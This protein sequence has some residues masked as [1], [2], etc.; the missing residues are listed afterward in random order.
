MSTFPFICFGEVLWDQ[1]PDGPRIGGAP[2][3][4]AA[5][6]HNLGV[7]SYLVSA[8]GKDV[9]GKKILEEMTGRGLSTRYVQQVD[10]VPTG[11]VHV[12]EISGKPSYEISKEAAWDQ[13]GFRP[14]LDQLAASARAICFGSLSQRNETSRATLKRIVSLLSP[15][16]IRFF[17]INLRHPFPASELLLENF[18]R[19]TI[20][21]LNDEELPQVVDWF[22]IGSAEPELFSKW[23][24]ERFPIQAVLLTQGSRGA[25]IGTRQDSF[26]VA[27]EPV[28]RLVDTVG[29]G[30]AFSAGFLSA[31]L[32]RKN[33]W[34]GA[35][36][37]G[38][39]CAAGACQCR[40][41]W[42]E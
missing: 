18:H 36:L 5:Q 14:E 21:K 9:N 22:G 7:E 34:I 37:A 42:P 8:V 24:F 6:A 20:L 10:G 4:C 15:E 19:T 27:A 31:L 12:M 40:G 29:A 41:A 11:V 16:A 33:D 17:D 38:A 23:L 13:I 28:V 25:W 1:L 35:A 26:H 30:D 32:R 39:A 3:N 2:A